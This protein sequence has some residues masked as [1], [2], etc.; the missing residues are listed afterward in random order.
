MKN[1]SLIL[2]VAIFIILIL[3]NIANASTVMYM[4]CGVN[5]GCQNNKKC[6]SSDE[7]NTINRIAKI[8]D[9]NTGNVNYALVTEQTSKE[10][11]RIANGLQ[12]SP[13]APIPFS[14]Y[15]WIKGDLSSIDKKCTSDKTPKYSEKPT[16]ILNKQICP[17]AI[18]K[19]AGDD[20]VPVGQTTSAKNVEI[21]NENRY[22]IYSFV[23]L[24]GNVTRIAEGYNSDGKFAFASGNRVFVFSDAG[25]VEWHQRQLINALH[26]E[27]YKIDT[28]FDTLMVSR[29]GYITNL[30]ICE[31]KDDCIKN[32]SFKVIS[33][34]NDSNGLIK[35][36]IQKWYD[37]QKSSING[38][39]NI[40]ELIENK[41]LIAASQEINENLGN[42]KSYTF[43]SNYSFENL[44]SDLDYAYTGLKEIFDTYTFTDYSTGNKTSLVSSAMSYVYKNV[45]EIDEIRDISETDDKSYIF[46]AGIIV[47][48]IQDLVEKKVNEVSNNETLDIINLNKNAEKYTEMFYTTIL[49]L[50]R[51][52]DKLN[53]TEQQ[54]KTLSDLKEKYK[55][56]GDKLNIKP[57]VDCETLLGEDLINKINS[58]L[59]IIRISVP[60]LLLVYGIMDFVKALFSPEEGEMKKAQQTFMKRL[61]I[62]VLIFLVPILVNLLLNLANQVWSTITPGTCGIYE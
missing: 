54:K 51:D 52:A 1:K 8:T 32:H 26:G 31:S 23:D 37:I 45:M 50:N 7:Q 36:N 22:I 48:S 2:R 38:L 56:L 62:A 14:T 44:M 4:E 58:Y 20:A 57:V 40:N 33:D 47:N 49:Y 15:C 61:L 27:Y 21:I 18:R 6:L 41:K 24:K 30:S 11:E 10:K 59:K 43:S 25:A 5:S 39:K 3:P 19:G 53:L 46:N 9:G 42:N 17:M 35:S 16:Q 60:I 28:N 13:D 55:A 29:T 34:S 12:I